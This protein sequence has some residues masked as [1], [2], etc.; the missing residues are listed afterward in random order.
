MLLI[1]TLQI[2]SFGKNV[3]FPLALAWNASAVDAEIQKK[4]YG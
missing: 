2:C 4:I 1:G 3:L